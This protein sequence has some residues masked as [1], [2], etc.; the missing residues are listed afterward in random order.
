MIALLIAALAAAPPAA[1][2]SLAV[3]AGATLALRAEGRGVQI[4]VCEQH[5]D[6]PQQFGWR[7]TGPQA[8][9]LDAD[10]KA[11]GRH[12]AGPTW[13][14]QDGGKVVGEVKAKAASP[15]GTAIDWLLLSAKSA[16]GGPGVIGRA[17]FIQRLSTIGGLPPTR[18]CSGDN[19]GDQVRV[20]YSAEYDFYTADGN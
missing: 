6:Q 10:G 7:L 16:T 18:V 19:L 3:P 9:L 4:Y 15:N 8:T 1:P 14:G 13:Q 11:V 12:F 2:A 17:S 20:P 5:P